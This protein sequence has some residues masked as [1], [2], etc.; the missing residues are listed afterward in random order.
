ML[1]RSLTV[2]VAL[3]LLILCGLGS[4]TL[5][6]AKPLSQEGE[7]LDF[8]IKSCSDFSVAESHLQAAFHTVVK[9]YKTI[10][11][12][13]EPVGELEGI[14]TP[15]KVQE[16]MTW[17]ANGGMIEMDSTGEM[18]RA[19]MLMKF[20]EAKSL[21]AGLFIARETALNA[22]FFADKLLKQC[23]GKSLYKR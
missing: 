5:D 18:C 14:E 2:S 13:K 6:E 21:K 12:Q 10:P 7:I 4:A 20:G 19:E 11:G 16:F 23:T 8:T 15:E 22:E 9:G 17:F 1:H 3:S